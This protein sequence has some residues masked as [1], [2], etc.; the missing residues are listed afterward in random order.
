[1][2]LD[3]PIIVIGAGRSGSTLLDRILNAHP[4]IHMLGETNFISATLWKTLL[5]GDKKTLL[6]ISDPD[7]VNIELDRLG[8]LILNT[9]GELFRLTSTGKPLTCLAKQIL[10]LR[11]IGDACWVYSNGRYFRFWG[12]KEIWNGDRE[13]V[14]WRI[15][16]KVF[17][18]ATWVHL[19]RNPL[20]YARS[21]IDWNGVEMTET[22]LA[23]QLKSWSRM[24][25]VSRERKSTGRFVEIRY[26]DLISDA[27]TA[28][29]PLF[30][31][32]GL[33]YSSSCSSPLKN[34]WV[35]SKS[36]SE[37]PKMFLTK[38][39][40]IVE[41][42][43]KLDSLG[44]EIAK[45]EP[46]R[47]ICFSANQDIEKE[48]EE[49]SHKPNL[50]VKESVHLTNGSKAKDSLLFNPDEIEPDSGFSFTYWVPLLAGEADS[51]EQQNRSLYLLTE[52]GKPLGPPHAIHANIREQG[53][54]HWSHWGQ[55]VYFSSSDGTNPRYNNRKYALTK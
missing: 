9:V 29:A 49:Q 16:D 1:M 31:M 7:L 35:A 22:V 3:A 2:R 8:R 17:P 18:N 11:A 45:D 40:G 36:P 55:T 51:T 13:T 52:D 26:E 50:L 27:E 32:L 4:A 12:M 46:A 25:D 38:L 42:Q 30:A 23:N 54:G 39:M 44:Y 37:I 15:Y 53:K 33:S 28:L 48:N 24:V 10:L 21:A 47:E 34:L 20:D 5:A 6:S 41:L 43:E 14:D 19:V